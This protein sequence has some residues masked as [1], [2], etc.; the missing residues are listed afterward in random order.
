M[1]ERAE[2]GVSGTMG[3]RWEDMERVPMP[4]PSASG[5]KVGRRSAETAEA[6][7][8]WPLTSIIDVT[9]MAASRS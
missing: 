5:A 6:W 7:W 9:R 8:L 3:P 1:R 4:G 2:A